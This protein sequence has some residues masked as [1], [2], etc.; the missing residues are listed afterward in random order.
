VNVS[1]RLAERMSNLRGGVVPYSVRS[2]WEKRVDQR[3][4]GRGH[5]RLGLQVSPGGG[6]GAGG[7]P[8]IPDL[9]RG[10]RS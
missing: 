6:V 8:K 5:G 2:F 9:R 1:M 10:R 4:G 3:Q 7:G